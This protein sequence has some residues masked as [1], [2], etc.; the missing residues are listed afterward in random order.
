MNTNGLNDQNRVY[1]NI[2][3]QPVN[4]INPNPQPVAYADQMPLQTYQ[5]IAPQAQGQH[6]QVVNTNN[7]NQ[8]ILPPANQQQVSLSTQ[9]GAISS[10][11]IQPLS[12]NTPQK[13]VEQSQPLPQ[14]KEKK[15]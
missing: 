10:I 12:N 8:A 5:Q 4:N 3:S 11:N 14:A 6:G 9:T 2:P 15:D 7:I 1:Q 13:T